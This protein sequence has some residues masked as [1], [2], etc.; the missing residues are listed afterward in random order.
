MSLEPMP[1]YVFKVFP[2]KTC[3]QI[4]DFDQY[5][6]ARALARDTRANL[7]LQDNCTV[8]VIF[9]KNSAEAETL[10]LTPR[11]RPILMEHEK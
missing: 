8:K 4:G 2:N 9:A 1:Y 3:E 6:E 11:E 10:I 5:K 7:T